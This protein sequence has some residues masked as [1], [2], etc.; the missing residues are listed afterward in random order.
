MA[1]QEIERHFDRKKPVQLIRLPRGSQSVLATSVKSDTH[2]REQNFAV[3][4]GDAS[5]SL[6]IQADLNAAGVKT[7][8][9]IQFLTHREVVPLEAHSHTA[10]AAVQMPPTLTGGTPE[11]ALGENGFDGDF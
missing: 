9:P 8:T 5:V 7:P 1:A 3:V 10:Y 6:A 2:R 4:K 11:R